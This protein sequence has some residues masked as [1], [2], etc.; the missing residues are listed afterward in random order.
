[1]KKLWKMLVGGYYYQVKHSPE[2]D[3]SGL[4]G[5]CDFENKVIHLVDPKCMATLLHEIYHASL[6][7]AG[8]AQVL[9]TEVHE[10]IVENL[11]QTTTRLFDL[12]VKRHGR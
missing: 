11:A 4:E 9:T 7:E 3:A 6:L 10:I 12:K 1:M 8:V 5:L 2:I